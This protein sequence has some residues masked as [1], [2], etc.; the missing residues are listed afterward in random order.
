M[1]K[2]IIKWWDY[3]DTKATLIPNGYDKTIIGKVSI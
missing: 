3:C 1:L 2:P